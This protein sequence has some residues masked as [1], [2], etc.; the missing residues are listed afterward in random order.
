MYV[1]SKICY[2][3]FNF[4]N[5][6]QVCPKNDECS[7][8]VDTTRTL[9]SPTSL[10]I[11]E[12]RAPSP[13]STALQQGQISPHHLPRHHQSPK[14]GS[15]GTGSPTS[16]QSRGSFRRRNKSAGAIVKSTFEQYEEKPLPALRQ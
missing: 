14:T 2:L 7:D 10:K 9:M 6:T 3:S 1:I 4:D 16:I 12:K 5:L 11:P 15:P 13:N 8:D